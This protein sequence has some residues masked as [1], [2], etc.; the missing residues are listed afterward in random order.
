MI[1]TAERNRGSVCI[2]NIPYWEVYFPEAC[3][4]ESLPADLSDFYCFYKETNATSSEMLIRSLKD[5]RLA[6]KVKKLRVYMYFHQPSSC[7][8]SPLW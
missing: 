4:K 2:S 7:Q 5:M 8:R 3:I 6:R 1:L